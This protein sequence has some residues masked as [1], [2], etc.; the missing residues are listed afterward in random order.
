MN[1]IHRTMILLAGLM[2]VT[3]LC[4]PESRAQARRAAAPAPAKDKVEIK[5]LDG[6][7]RSGRVKTPEYDLNPR[8]TSSTIHEWSRIRVR[9]ATTADW[10]D[11]LVCSYYVQARNPKTK[12]SVLFT[13]K[14]TYNDI[15]KGKNHLVTAFL[16]PATLARYG[17]VIGIAV[18]IHAKG[19]M[20][21][22]AC[23][24]KTPQG[25]WRLTKAKAMP[26]V[27]LERSQTPFA[28]VAYDNYVPAKPR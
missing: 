18:E 7:G 15:P 21:A 27:L 26:G 13:G 2:V 12:K 20:V 1:T 19:E 9:F 28:F 5:K 4:A 3:A 23:D 11:E 25:W 17:D 16:R 24:P 10:T 14:F 6:V 8:Q 22:Y